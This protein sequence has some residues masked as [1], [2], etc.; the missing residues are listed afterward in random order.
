[1]SEQLNDFKV[2]LIK[3]FDLF[4]SFKEK[5]NTEKYNIL[6]EFLLVFKAAKPKELQINFTPF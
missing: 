5:D 2:I 3:L 4:F 1:M 6:N